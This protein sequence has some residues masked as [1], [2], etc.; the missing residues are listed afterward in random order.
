MTGLPIYVVVLHLTHVQIK[1]PGCSL[2]F[3]AVA[4]IAYYYQLLLLS[5]LDAVCGSVLGTTGDEG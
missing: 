5:V 3:L 2:V 1:T 4:A